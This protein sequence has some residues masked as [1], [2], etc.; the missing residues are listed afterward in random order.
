MPFATT[1]PRRSATR[2]KPPSPTS[3]NRKHQLMSLPDNDAIM[4]QVQILAQEARD[5]QS[6]PAASPP[7]DVVVGVVAPIYMGKDHEVIPDHY[8]LHYSTTR[9]TNC[10]SQTSESTFYGLS[11]IRSRVNGTRVRHLVKVPRPLF[12]LPVKRIPTGT[13]TTPFC[14]E[15]AEIDL[16]HLPPPPSPSQLYDLAEPRLKGAK[17]KVDKPVTTKKPTLDDLI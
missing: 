6:N 13:H 11:Y 9:C 16:S 1:P 2:R 17:P 5:V 4:D 7:A 12:N 3:P 10:G 8:V 15:C 14:C